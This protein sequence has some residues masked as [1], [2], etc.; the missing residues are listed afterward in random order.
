MEKHNYF[1]FEGGINKSKFVQFYIMHKNG[2]KWDLPFFSI[3]SKTYS[4]TRLQRLRLTNSYAWHIMD[5]Q[6]EG[7]LTHVG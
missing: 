3:L 4:F 6:T 2:E 7:V 1:D 5:M